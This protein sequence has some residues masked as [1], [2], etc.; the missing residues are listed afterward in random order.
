MPQTLI[1]APEAVDAKEEHCRWPSG[2][3]AA[4]E[5]LPEAVVEQRPI[6]EVGQQIVERYLGQL[7]FEGLA[8][9]DV[10]RGQHDLAHGRIV[11]QIGGDRLDLPPVASPIPETPFNR[12]GN[13]PSGYHVCEEGPHGVPIIRM[14]EADDR[15]AD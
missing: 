15:L 7:L 5:G 6:R 8:H 2:P 11:A 9:P 4:R 13:R 14:G 1:Y 10:S 3:L 12:P